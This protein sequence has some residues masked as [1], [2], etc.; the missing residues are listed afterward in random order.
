VNSF[1]QLRVVDVATGFDVAPAFYDDNFFSLAPGESRVVVA[2]M[3]TLRRDA[4]V[5][6][7]VETYNDMV[8]WAE[9]EN[10]GVGF[11]KVVPLSPPQTLAPQPPP[12]PPAPSSAPSPATPTPG[13][14]TQAPAAAAN[15]DD[16]VAR[17]EYVAAVTAACLTTLL[18]L[19]ATYFAFRFK[20]EAQAGTTS[21]Y[22]SFEANHASSTTPLQQT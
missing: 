22:R 9:R 10:G 8:A 14:P 3:P 12:V 11:S 1:I 15:D 2:E 5:R 13:A 20:R 18:A 16:T 17:G 6:I 21:S 4:A 19:V 7:E